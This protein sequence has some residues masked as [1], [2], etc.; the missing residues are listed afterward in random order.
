MSPT[1]TFAVVLAIVAIACGAL[2]FLRSGPS[3]AESGVA[4][5]LDTPL[6]SPRRVPQPLVDAVGS[7]RLQGALDAEV[8]DLN[9]CFVV[10]EGG[11]PLATHGGDAAL[12][13]ASTQKILTAAAALV[14][15]GPEQRFVTRAVAAQAPQDG[16]I[17][18]LFLV[19]GGD[20]LLMTPDVQALR[21][22]I[23][24]LRGTPTTSMASLADAIVAAGV[25]RIPGGIAAD[26]TR[27]EAVRYIPTWDDDYRT[28][29]QVGPLGALTVNGGFRELRPPQP[30][31]DPA[32]LATEKL[33]ELLEERGVDVGG[34]AG[35]ETAPPNAVEVGTVESPPLTDVLGEDLSTSNNLASE[36]LTREIGLQASQQG[37]TAAGAQAIAAKLAE[38]G[39]PTT[40]VALVDGSGLDKG[41]RATCPSLAAALDLGSDPR[42]AILWDGL[43]VAGERGTLV[44]QIGGDLTGK[45]RGKTGTLSN[46]SGLVG[47]VDVTRPLRFAFLANAEMSEPAAIALRRRIVEIIATFPDA[48]PAD[49][50]VPTPGGPREDAAGQDATTQP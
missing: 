39:V 3:A 16:T 38:L 29:G 7:Q 14:V 31:D 34:G 33:G 11:A 27:Y 1:R 10:D 19:G 5:S 48:P 40:N 24:E 49:E 25:K 12:V 20:A 4:A 22:D 47:I 15:L 36:L 30:A 2:A 28:E 41:N 13:P 43:A 17:E 45:V 44:D 21:E 6:W 32:L 46:A 50:L 26:D 42:Y 8:G 9:T 37:T 35:H 23:P 18:K